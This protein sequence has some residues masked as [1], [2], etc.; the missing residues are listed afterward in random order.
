VISDRIKNSKALRSPG[1]WIALLYLFLS[2]QAI[3]LLMFKCGELQGR[4]QS[5]YYTSLVLAREAGTA[6]AQVDIL[7]GDIQESPTS[8]PRTEEEP[9]LIDRLLLGRDSTDSDF[10]SYE[11]AFWDAYLNEVNKQ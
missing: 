4:N 8:F 9:D 7:K 5:L 6:Q 1:F 3:I 2:H 10:E 11:S